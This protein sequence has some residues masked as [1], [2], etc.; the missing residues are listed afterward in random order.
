[1][2]AEPNMM[3]QARE[4][5]KETGRL[6]AFS[7]GVF[8]IAITLL[9]LE[10]RVP[11]PGEGD[12]AR[13]LVAALG[14]LWPSYLAYVLSFLVIAVMWVN[15]HHLFKHITRTDNL[16]MFLNSLLLMVITFVNFSTALLADYLGH[17]EEQV[18]ALVYAGTMVVISILFNI[19]WR[20]A[21]ANNRLLARNADPA[22][23]TAITRGYRW[24]PIL[25]SLAFVLVFFNSGHILSLALQFGLAVYFALTGV[26]R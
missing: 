3:N 21:S 25:Y 16:L 5:E 24:G 13:S 8:A 9:I 2:G 10:I 20:Y 22:M 4:N 11:A 14:D 19:L 17:P 1:M 15:H 23:V 12:A 18:A 7:D 6:E 26:R